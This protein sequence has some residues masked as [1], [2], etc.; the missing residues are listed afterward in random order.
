M[1]IVAFIYNGTELPSDILS[2]MS[3]QMSNFVAASSSITVKKFNEEDLVK[4]GIK[5]AVESMPNKDEALE[6]AATYISTRFGSF[7][8]TPVTMVL[9][10]SEKKNSTTEEA[11][12]L[13]NAVSIIVENLGNP[14]LKKYDITPSV[15][16]VIKEFSTCY[17][18]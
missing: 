11:T 1:K 10:M 12:I 16:K 7:F 5:T 15:A 3:R 17:H 6:H 14:L 4:L 13:K 18:V 2:T 9:A 8:K